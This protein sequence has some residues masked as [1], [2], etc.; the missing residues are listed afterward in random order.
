MT[1]REVD[2][3][4]FDEHVLH[5]DDPV[6]VDFRAAWCGPCKAQAPILERF[7]ATAEGRAKV[8]K[9]DVDANA[10]LAGRYGV[11]SIPTLLLFHG[12]EVR[13]TRVGLSRGADLEALLAAP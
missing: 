12:G 3:R 8:V 6:L 5:A 7:A 2:G 13:A 9:V 4:S 1:I 11:R 10:E